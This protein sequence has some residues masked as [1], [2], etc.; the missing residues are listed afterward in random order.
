LRPLLMV[1]GL[2]AGLVVLTVFIPFIGASIWVAEVVND[3]AGVN[4]GF[5]MRLTVIFV[6]S[7]LMLYVCYRC[8]NL[9]THVPDR[10]LRW[11]GHG[12]EGLGE[13]EPVEQSKAIFLGG[14]GNMSAI[15]RISSRITPSEPK[16]PENQSALTKGQ[17][18]SGRGKN[19]D[20]SQT[21][22]PYRST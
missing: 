7:F 19:Q 21:R 15:T 2:V 11:I 4:G 5:Y 17:G 6:Q 16:Q 10:V 9:I 12:G 14:L 8:F 13:A 18:G 1:V 22:D 20:N 3:S